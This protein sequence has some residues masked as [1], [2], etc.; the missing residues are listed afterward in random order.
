VS[1]NFLASSASDKGLPG[2]ASVDLD[3][4][5]SGILWLRRAAPQPDLVSAVAVNERVTSRETAGTV[6]DPPPFAAT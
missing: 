6:K 4:G 3:A 2:G 1:W 5:I